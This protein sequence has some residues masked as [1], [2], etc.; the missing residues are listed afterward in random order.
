[1]SQTAMMCRPTCCSIRQRS[2]GFQNRQVHPMEG[3]V[4]DKLRFLM[5]AVTICYTMEHQCLVWYMWYQWY[6]VWCGGKF[7]HSA[8]TRCKLL[9]KFLKLDTSAARL[10]RPTAEFFKAFSRLVASCCSNF[11]LFCFEDLWSQVPANLLPCILHLG[12]GSPRV[13]PTWEGLSFQ[14]VAWLEAIVLLNVARAAWES[15]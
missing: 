1:M 2:T 4:W 12:K 13:Q 14:A 6:G 8:E 11:P 15:Q 10:L 7:C 9:R 5:F 3:E